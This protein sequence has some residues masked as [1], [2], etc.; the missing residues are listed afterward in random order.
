MKF[1]E[2]KDTVAE[3]TI[4]TN[5]EGGEAFEPDSPEMALYKVTINN[6]LENTH[7]T[8]DQEQLQK[9]TKRFDAIAEENPEFALKLA[10]Y[11][12]NKIGLRDVSQ[13]LLVL[14]A[15]DD[16]TKKFVK[17]YADD[18]MVRTD[19]PCTV[20]AI[21]D[22][23]F[24][25]TLPKPLKK[26]INDA[27]HQWDKYQF[28]KYDNDSRQVNIRDVI[29][30][31][32]P[33]PRDELREEIFERLMKGDLDKYPE[34]EPLNESQGATW[35]TTISE[36]GN[37]G[38]AWNEVKGRMGIMAKLR[39]VRNMKQAGLKGEEIL[40]EEDFEAVRNSRMFPFR[41]Y[42]SY[43]AVKNAG[44]LDPH[45]DE[46]IEKAIDLTAENLPDQLE[47]TF[48]GVD[49]SGSMRTAV[50][51]KSN[52]ECKEIATL[53]GSVAMKKGA[54]AGVFASEFMEVK[55]HSQT[56]SL[57][58]ADKMQKAGVGGSTN[59]WKV[60]EYLTDNEIEVD[61]IVMMTDMQ[62]WDS[63]SYH[64]RNNRT[65]K[66]AFEDYKQKVNSEAS[67]Y[68]LDL[69]SYGDLVTPEGYED[70]YNISGWNSKILEFIEYAEKPGEIIEEIENYER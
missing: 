17:E 43:K 67:L 50:S 47:S 16:R 52:L 54:R 45:I 61:R 58:I 66:R 30:R 27:L 32:H 9:V 40:T 23:L 42:Q 26:G 68:M 60:I 70:V 29:N 59:G 57:E 12:R 39:N 4:K 18:I 63:Q 36:K 46:W 65:V 15:N 44:V 5:Y 37:N 1:N 8:E 21:H 48:V 2:T 11:S 33:K 22:E 13:L 55:A 62:I 10:A 28:D 38:E 19:E 14:S 24:G 51:N 64:S 69:Q 31:T 49:T 20:V 7:Y 41:L 34:I 53:F 3:R 6:L 56:P 25:G 35:E